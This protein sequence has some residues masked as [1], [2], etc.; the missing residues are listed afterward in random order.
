MVL[1]TP[2]GAILSFTAY[3]F[4]IPKAKVIQQP[5]LE[6]AKEEVKGEEENFLPSDSS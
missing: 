4:L 5:K 3:K 6:E 2:L 1:T